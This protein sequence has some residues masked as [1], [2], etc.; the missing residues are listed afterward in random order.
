MPEVQEAIKAVIDSGEFSLAQIAPILKKGYG[1]CTAFSFWLAD[2]GIIECP[3]GHF[4][5]YYISDESGCGILF[6]FN[7]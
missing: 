7:E 4:L 2:N 6:F 5:C 1:R 3:S